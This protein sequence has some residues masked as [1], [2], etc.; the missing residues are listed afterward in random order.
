MVPTESQH[1]RCTLHGHLK[2]EP[3]CC[4][5][6]RHSYRVELGLDVIA[7]QRA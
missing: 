7:L 4:G 6:E 3:Y 5:V 2:S 1:F